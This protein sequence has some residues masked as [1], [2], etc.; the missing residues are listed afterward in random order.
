ML[1]SFKGCESQRRNKALVQII[2][3]QNH[4]EQAA[5]QQPVARAPKGLRRRPPY[6]ISRPGTYFLRSSVA[7][8][9]AWLRVTNTD[10]TV[11]SG[12]R[13]VKPTTTPSASIS[14]YTLKS[15]THFT[16]LPRINHS[17]FTEPFR[18]SVIPQPTPNCH[19]R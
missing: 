16:G 14:S 6:Q 18:P 3:F 13:T 17:S 5:P 1:M 12:L 10:E 9:I 19:H 4:S 7:K 15:P 8:S 2:R 11:P